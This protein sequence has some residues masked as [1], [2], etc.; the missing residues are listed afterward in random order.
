MIS[1]S[2]QLKAVPTR[3]AWVHTAKCRTGRMR[4]NHRIQ[5]GVSLPNAMK[6]PDRN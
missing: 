5:E 4:A 3:A 6:I 1:T 2:H